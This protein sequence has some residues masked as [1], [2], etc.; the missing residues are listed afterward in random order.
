MTKQI[1]G[2]RFD[3]GFIRLP[4][5]PFSGHDLYGDLRSYLIKEYGRHLSYQRL[6]KMVDM[7]TSKAHH[8]FA[9]FHHP[10]VQAFMAWMEYLSPD[11]CHAYIDA[12][13]RKLPSLRDVRLT[14]SPD[15]V[16]ELESL[17]E[18]ECGLTVLTGGTDEMRT[19]LVTALGH[20]CFRGAKNHTIPRGIDL[21]RP[22]NFVPVE[23]MLYANPAWDAEKIRNL[24]IDVFPRILVSATTLLIFNRVWSWVPEIRKDIL[25]CARRKHVILAEETFPNQQ[26]VGLLPPVPVRVVTVSSSRKAV[27]GIRVT[28]RRMTD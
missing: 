3:E 16:G 24:V 20:A 10:Q 11:A 17:I 4:A 14:H 18:Q 19:Y 28:F 22:A 9:L 25:R 7:G 13:R 5:Y 1:G 2:K 26:D 6:G 15:G 8:W 21:H 27:N 12:H 23:S